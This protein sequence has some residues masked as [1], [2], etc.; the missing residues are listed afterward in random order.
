MKKLNL[1][2][3]ATI[4]NILL[5]SAV[6]QSVDFRSLNNKSIV[7]PS[8][9]IA[10]QRIIVLEGDIVNGNSLPVDFLYSSNVSTINSID[11]QWNVVFSDIQLVQNDIEQLVKQSLSSSQFGTTILP[12]NYQING[13]LNFSGFVHLNGSGSEEFIFNVTGNVDFADFTTILTDGLN[14]KNIVWNVAG[15]VAAGHNSVVSGIFLAEG[16]IDFEKHIMGPVSL[17]SETNDIKLSSLL[18]IHSPDGL[19][20]P[21]GTPENFDA[22]STGPSLVPG[23]SCVPGTSSPMADPA[24]WMKDQNYNLNAPLIEIGVNFHIM[25]DALGGNNFQNIAKQ[26]ILILTQ[27]FDWG[28]DI[29]RWPRSPSSA[30]TSVCGTCYVQDTK[31][32]LVLKR[33]EFYQS[34]ALNVSTYAGLQTAMTARDPSMIKDVNIFWTEGNLQPSATGHANFPRDINGS[35]NEDFMFV[36]MFEK[37][38]GPNIFNPTLPASFVQG[39]YAHGA[40][41]A[42]EV[43]HNLSLNH[44][45]GPG[46]GSAICNVNDINYLDD[47]HGPVG[48]QTCPHAPSPSLWQCVPGTNANCTNNVMGGNR[49]SQYISPKQLGQINIALRTKSMRQKINNCPFSATPLEVTT[50]QTWDKDI[51]LFRDVR[52]KNN[53]VLTIT[54]KVGMPETGRIVVEEGSKLVIDG[55]HITNS[56]KEKFWGGIV[57]KGN[58]SANQLPLSQPLSQGKLEIK[59]GAIIENVMYAITFGKEGGW[60]NFGGLVEAEDATFRVARRAVEFM[61]YPNQVNHSYFKRCTFEYVPS[62]TETPLSL[63]TLWDNK[64][65]VFSGCTFEDNTGINDYYPNVANGIYSIDAAYTVKSDCDPPSPQSQCPVANF[66]QSTFKNLNQGV[67]ATG[68]ATGSKTVSVE[69]VE[70]ENN[71][72]ALRVDALDNVSFIKNTFDEGGPFKNLYTG[73]YLY[74][75]NINQATGYEVEQNTFNKTGTVATIGLNIKESGDAPNEIYNN[76]FN[77][78]NFEQRHQDQNKHPLTNFQG[79]ELLCNFHINGNP[80]VAISVTSDFS[81]PNASFLHGVRVFQGST[82]SSAAN[83]FTGSGIKVSNSAGPIDYHYQSANQDPN[84]FAGAVNRITVN[85]S[86]VCNTR[87]LLR[88]QSRIQLSPIMLANYYTDLS[89]YEAL[90]YNYYQN[91]DG[92]NT[93]ALVANINTTFPNEAQ[94]LRDDLMQEAPY[95]SQEAIMEAASTGILNDALLLEICLANPDATKS[96]GFLDFLEFEIPNI[97]PATMIQ[98]IYQNWDAETPRT[99]LELQLA[100]WNSKVGRAASQILT[101]YSLDTLDHTDSIESMLKSKKTLR[102]EY[103]QVELAIGNEQSVKAMSLLNAI[104]QQYD[105]ND[106]QLLEQNNFVNYANFRANIL[107]EGLSYMQLAESHLVSLRGISQAGDLRSASLAQNILCFG[108]EECATVPSAQGR[109]KQGRQYDFEGTTFNTAVSWKVELSPNPASDFVAIEVEGIETE[110]VISF[111]IQNTEGKVLLE[112]QLQQSNNTL[113][114]SDY[115]NGIY[116]ITFKRSDNTTVSKKLIIQ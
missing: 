84:P 90:L 50:T 51:F 16:Q 59:N 101:Y 12:G 60:F 71:T 83:T 2:K 8:N 1:I 35:T 81:A 10:S 87:H 109:L 103:Q 45:Y 73:G 25:Q 27:L 97:L 19:T 63:V 37:Y 31:I 41:L 62:I 106:K 40:A 70:F 5:G 93:Q 72:M 108:Y 29:I 43:G 32:Q 89:T 49:D 15:D 55:G 92:G 28:S 6:A 98:L 104:P 68:A 20:A 58:N 69:G 115:S 22:C 47:V 111:A 96:E 105:L 114:L 23:V 94:Q 56:C 64:G 107:S 67:F 95:L 42:H 88:V 13:D 65:A 9:I 30:I 26:D 85:S 7:S 39:H 38:T 17:F 33:I 61:S 3:Y 4:I 34:N 79:L 53:S 110:E 11:P 46:I 52:V 100:N 77:G 18:N 54:C 91:I 82:S 74:G 78:N 24:N 86:N 76:T 21:A 14:P 48:A 116:F 113:D 102:S 57:V 112:S 80:S 75:V 44:T 99:L 66:T 36:V